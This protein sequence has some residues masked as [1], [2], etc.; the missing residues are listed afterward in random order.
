MSVELSQPDVGTL[1]GTDYVT[2]SSMSTFGAC[3]RM[4]YYAYVLGWRPERVATALR[5]GSILHVGIDQL[6]KGDDIDAACA[7]IEELYERRTLDVAQAMDFDY[8]AYKLGL[9]STTVQRLL[10]GY[11]YAYRDSPLRIV[12][13]EATFDLPIINP[14]TGRAARIYRQA[15]KR[16]R[17]ARLP[18]P[19]EPVVLLETKT[20]NEDIGPESD[21]RRVLLLNQQLSMYV[22]AAQ[23]QGWD[24][25]RIV[26]DVI[27]KPT[28]KPTAVPVLDESKDKIVLDR[29]GKRVYTKQHKPRQTASI[30]DEWTVQ[31]LPM[32]RKQWGGKLDRDILERP[33][34]Y[35]QRFEVPR[36]DADL[37]E[38]Q[39]EL[40]DMAQDI[41]Q[42]HKTGRWYRRTSACRNYSR[43]CDYYPLCV[44]ECD[45]TAGCP[46]G[47]RQA[48]TVHEE[49]ADERSA[50]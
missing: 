9:E 50:S 17:M 41:N 49:L 30:A 1:A 22:L 26:Y 14:E 27:R 15:G 3:R 5:F 2:N 13:S 39:H 25:S 47:F 35:Y 21:Y 24:V 36:L 7:V 43:L 28:I 40:W 45:T 6:A 16:D 11:Y 38:F 34:F 44:G 46:A 29:D 31:T 32:T 23:A 12:E 37:E 33:E 10:R 18:E 48:E 19:G 20:A 4:Y 8:I 42:C